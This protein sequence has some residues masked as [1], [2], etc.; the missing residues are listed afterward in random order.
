MNSASFTSGGLGYPDPAQ[1]QEGNKFGSAYFDTHHKMVILTYLATRVLPGATDSSL[2]ETKSI[3]LLQA[4]ADDFIPMQIAPSSKITD[5]QV[6]G[7][8]A[9]YTVGAW[10]SEFVPDAKDPKGGQ[11]KSTWRNDLAIQNLYWQAGKIYLVLVCDDA[12]VS[13]T[14]LIDTTASLGK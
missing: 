9:V 11:M 8:L 6:N 1:L 13:Q 12:A 10:D 14:A 3:T 2:T 7:E 5:I 4:T